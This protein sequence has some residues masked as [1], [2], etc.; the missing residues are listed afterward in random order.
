LLPWTDVVGAAPAYVFEPLG[1]LPDLEGVR[2]GVLQ[3]GHAKVVALVGYRDDAEASEV[4]RHLPYGH[5]GE[6]IE[7]I[8]FARTVPIDRIVEFEDD[9]WPGEDR[10]YVLDDPTEALALATRFAI[11]YGAENSV[12]LVTG[13]REFVE[14]V[15]A[16]LTAD[17]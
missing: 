15:R 11:E 13:H 16:G 2:A 3:G 8:V 12:V 17:D 1:T 7:E 10:T 4:A 5:R 14:S 9:A 6:G